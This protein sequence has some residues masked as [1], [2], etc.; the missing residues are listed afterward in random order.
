[1]ISTAAAGVMKAE[2]SNTATFSPAAAGSPAESLTIGLISEERNPPQP[3]ASGA[4]QALSTR[5]VPLA[6]SRLPS[7]RN[8][9]SP[10]LPSIG[11]VGLGGLGS[12][13]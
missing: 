5:V 12:V 7:S 2:L 1:L 8:S 13:G 6:S 11:L 9:I 3:P 4:A 10:A